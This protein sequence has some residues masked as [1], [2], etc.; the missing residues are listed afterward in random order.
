MMDPAHMKDVRDE[1]RAEIIQCLDRLYRARR[2]DLF[3]A[4]ILRVYGERGRPPD[5]KNRAESRDFAVWR[6]ALDRLEWQLR[7]RGI[8]AAKNE[9]VFQNVR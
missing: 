8:V 1:T 5:P 4:R 2:I 6:E 3:H 9:E 7:A